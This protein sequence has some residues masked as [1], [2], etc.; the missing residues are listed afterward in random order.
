MARSWLANFKFVM[1]IE[2][3]LKIMCD[4]ILQKGAIVHL[5][6]MLKRALQWGTCMLHHV[7]LPLRHKFF[8]EDGKTNSKFD[9]TVNNTIK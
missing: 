9:S 5:E 1:R 7:E 4:D 3:M 6:R 2:K 8:H